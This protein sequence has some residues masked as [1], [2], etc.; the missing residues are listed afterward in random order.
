MFKDLFHLLKTSSVRKSKSYHLNLLDILQTQCITNIP[1]LRMKF[2][3][4]C[5]DSR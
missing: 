2:L 1:I 4:T 5:T 3:I